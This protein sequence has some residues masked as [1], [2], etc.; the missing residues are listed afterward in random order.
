[1]RFPFWRFAP[2]VWIPYLPVLAIYLALVAV[3]LGAGSA[4][5]APSLIWHDAPLTQLAAGLGAWLLCSQL[6]FVGY[7]IDGRENPA[8]LVQADTIGGLPP[9]S[10]P[11]AIGRIARYSIVPCTLLFVCL[12]GGAALRSKTNLHGVLV[13]VGPAVAFAWLVSVARKQD[14]ATLTQRLHLT[15]RPW[16]ARLVNALWRR[17]PTETDSA[18]GPAVHM[19]Q[20]TL[21]VGF[22]AFYVA[23]GILQ[24]VAPFGRLPPAAL[25]V[26][27]ALA[28]VAGFWGFLRF[29][30][31]RYRLVVGALAILALLAT[32]MD[33]RFGVSDVR[34]PA[35]LARPTRAVDDDAALAAWRE[36]QP[37]E[38][39]PLVVVATSGG[40]LRAAI[41]TINVLGTLDRLHAGFLRHVRLVTGA[42][43]GMVGAA[44]LVSELQVRGENA[45]SLD[46]PALERI[47]KGAAGDSLTP[48]A[49]ALIFPFEERGRALERSWELYTGGRMGRPFRVL[50]PGEAAGWLPSL[51]YSPM[52]VEDGRRLLVSNLDLTELTASFPTA[53]GVP[54]M[55]SVQL[56]ACAGQGIEEIKLSTVA[57][58]NATFPWVTSAGRLDSDPDRRVV[59]AG[60]YDNYGVDLA[61]AWIRKNAQWIR[62]NT[63]GVL[64][65]QI[66]DALT[67]GQTVTAPDGPGPVTRLVSSLSTPIEA[68][69]NAREASML[70]R[71]DQKLEVL[72]DELAPF[73]STVA[74]EFPGEAPL[75]WYLNGE[76][77]EALTGALPAP[78]LATVDAWWRERTQPGQRAGSR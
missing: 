65:V 29:W 14:E 25:S 72:K 44:H 20:L 39:P 45:P 71:N 5:G 17:L 16:M 61:S 41:W 15:H 10:N 19:S 51:V 63:S 11:D 42:S 9:H 1:M 60:Y 62:A 74:F 46:A 56:F 3:I 47:V 26:C 48:V 77:V 30:Y 68:F 73:F 58:L 66:R 35:N 2:F 43:G 7:L 70:F 8:A 49:H 67:K 50:E 28:L 69:L 32:G 37:E 40:A 21:M 18:V 57:R 33:S 78:A 53:Q 27:F 76:T 64:V 36:R 23:W 24:L 4:L 22:L 6:C 55:S 54:S 75:E 13:L 34:F 31:R 38:K 52:M 59:D 12:L